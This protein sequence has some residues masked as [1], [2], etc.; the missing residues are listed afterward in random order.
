LPQG[1]SKKGNRP[2]D[3]DSDLLRNYTLSVGRI[4]WEEQDSDRVRRIALKIA[5]EV[6]PYGW[7]G[8]RPL[9]LE[10]P[11][12]DRTPGSTTA[13]LERHGALA[14]VNRTDKTDDALE[15]F[16]RAAEEAILAIANHRGRAAR[17]AERSIDERRE[18][19]LTA[20]A[21]LDFA[22]FRTYYPGQG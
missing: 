20:I 1:I 11:G 7:F 6:D 10:I 3:T 22:V 21:A 5:E 15:R 4:L 9:A 2:L 17:N 18:L 19:T 13:M 14:R 12:H 16:Q 8:L